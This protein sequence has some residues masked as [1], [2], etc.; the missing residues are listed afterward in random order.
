MRLLQCSS[1]QRQKCN[2]RVSQ[3]RELLLKG[4]S[5]LSHITTAAYVC[6]KTTL[7]KQHLHKLSFA[8]LQSKTEGIEYLFHQ[9]YSEEKKYPGNKSLAFDFV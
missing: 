1:T 9:N 7:A 6:L 5:I 4:T 8:L 2:C 3:W